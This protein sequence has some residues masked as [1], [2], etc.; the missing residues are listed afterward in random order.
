M[1]AKVHICTNGT[2]LQRITL[3]Y[4]IQI[5]HVRIMKFYQQK[6][7]FHD[8]VYLF[9]YNID[10]IPLATLYICSR[11]FDGLYDHSHGYGLI[12]PVS[13]NIL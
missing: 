8:I 12:T 5:L 4:M 11:V 3:P 9:T 7:V 10:C 13:T 1:P 2:P 6:N